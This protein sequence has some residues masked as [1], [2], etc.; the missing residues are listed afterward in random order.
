MTQPSSHP[1]APHG[2]VGVLLVNLGTPDAPTPTEVRRYLRRFLSDRRVI[3]LPRALWKP[4]LTLILCVRPK[5]VAHNYKMIWN[6]EHNVSPLLHYTRRQ[7]EA[8]AK[9]LPDVVVTPAMLY[10][11]PDVAASLAALRE[12]G[13]DKI[14]LAPLYPQYSATTTAAVCDEA[15]RALIGMRRQP[16][17]RVLPAFYDDPAYIAALAATYRR[18]I[19]GNAPD[20]TVFSFHGLP[21]RNLELGDPYYCHCKKTGRLLAEALGLEKNAY[22]VAFQS[23]FGRAEW[24]Q[25]YAVPTL[26]KLAQ[27][28]V[29]RVAVMTPGF[30]SDCLETLEEIS[31]GARA[32]F[33]K[34]G[35]ENFLYVPCLNDSQ[36][37]DDLFARLIA[38]ELEGWRA[39]R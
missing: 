27:G 30:A 39:Q 11:A 21:K 9:A 5:K 1:A 18:H 23:R 25:P 15:F 13:C 2:R 3:E 17:L 34:A 37:A 6:E 19:E 26:E 36:D 16:A 12:K 38:R 8:L 32:A 7:A 28:G 10:S 33:L 14:L 4:I 22:T 24:L 35:G 31:I 29:R 20:H